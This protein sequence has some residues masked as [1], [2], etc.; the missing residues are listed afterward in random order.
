MRMQNLPPG[1]QAPTPCL[2]FVNVDW[3]SHCQTTK[4]VMNDVATRLG[5]ALPVVSINGDKHREFVTQYRIDGF[6]TIMFMAPDRAI[7]YEG[8]RSARDICDWACQQ[9]GR[10]GRNA[11][12]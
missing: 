9:S 2:A 5:T 3:C 6:P 7:P 11:T 10:C 8:P 4:P 1:R 12:Y